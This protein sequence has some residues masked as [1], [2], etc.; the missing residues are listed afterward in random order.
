MPRHNVRTA[1]LPL[2][3]KAAPDIL[4]GDVID[5]VALLKPRVMSLVVFTALVGMLVKPITVHPFIAAASLL[6]IALGAGASGC[7][8]MWWDSDIDA[9]MSRTRNRPIPAGRIDA[10]DALIF[11][12]WLSVGSVL[13]LGLISNWLAA[14]LLAMTILYYVVI[15]SVWLKRSTPQNIVIG[16][17][18]GAFPPMVA[19]AAVT[20]SV[21]LETVILF[22]IIFFW[23]P[24][25]FWA[26]AL[27][28]T[29]DYDRAGIPMLPNVAGKP[30]T[31]RAILY[32]TL[33]LAP[34][35]L[36]PCFA[37]FGGLLYAAVS[38]IGGIG[39]L[40][41]ALQIYKYQSGPLSNEGPRNMFRFSIL[42]LFSL[43]AALLAEH[44][45]GLLIAL[46]KLV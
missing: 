11:G 17:A 36:A 40:L 43:F 2:T 8:N 25:H 14:S 15:Y 23:T 19:Q 29:D 31:R 27:L 32:Y 45:L 26:L 4:K 34:L 42:Y 7:L 41:L 21:G 35:G 5:Y 46:P 1:T 33:I 18:A 20:G 22:L 39:M 13:M 6:M 30:A 3:S 12:S 24:P 44:G 9:R 10:G 37:G 28:K 16:G 38:L